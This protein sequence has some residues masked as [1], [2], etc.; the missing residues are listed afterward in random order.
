MKN[1][2]ITLQLDDELYEYI[3][4]SAA[5]LGL[6]VSA[7]VRMILLQKKKTNRDE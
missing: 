1:H 4:T 6:S 7:F 5:N 3:K 2:V